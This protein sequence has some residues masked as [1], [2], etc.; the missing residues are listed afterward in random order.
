MDRITSMEKIIVDNESIPSSD[1]EM[2]IEEEPQF[3]ED[4]SPEYN[5]LPDTE[6][7]KD[8]SESELSSDDEEVE[9]PQPTK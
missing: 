9:E 4:S 6:S 1:E 3:S 5:L 2:E 7:N 8:L